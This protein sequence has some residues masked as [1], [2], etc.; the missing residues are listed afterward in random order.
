M[1][2]GVEEAWRLIVHV[3]WQFF[4]WVAVVSWWTLVVAWGVTLMLGS[5]L[6][7][8]DSVW[9]FGLITVLIKIIARGKRRAELTAQE[10]EESAM[11]ERLER[12]VAEARMEAMQAQIE[13]HF[14]FNTLASIDQL[15]E[16]DPPRASRVQ[17]TLIRYLRA[18]MPKMRDG[19]S[20][21]T[22]G[23]Q[24]D[25][26]TAFLEIMQI[27]MEDRLRVTVTVPD[28]LRP[29]PFPPMMLQTLVENSIKHGLEPKAAGGELHI[30]ARLLDARLSVTVRDTGVGFSGTPGNGVGLANIR[31]RLR[32]LYGNTAELA[33]EVPEQGAQVS[34]ILPMDY[35][36]S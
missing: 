4:D 32:M 11:V 36:P 5:A 10:A 28:S 12:K 13:P 18:A 29:L 16:V 30:S 25:L 23:Q 2:Q 8:G 14:L 33:I 6:G 7:M 20:N 15:I 1:L 24:L 26:S 17:K 35:Q 3:W 27:R 9:R 21:S 34:I 22:L 19:S 31:E